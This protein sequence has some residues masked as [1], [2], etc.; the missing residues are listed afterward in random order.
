MERSS[1]GRRY[2]GSSVG[3]Y[4]KAG[5]DILD[6]PGLLRLSQADRYRYLCLCALAKRS[7]PHVGG[8][9]EIGTILVAPGQPM[10]VA[11]L[12]LQ[13]RESAK[14]VANFLDRL[15]KAMPGK[16]SR[17]DGELFLTSYARRQRNKP[18][19]NPEAV[20]ERVR[21]HRSGAQG[22]AN[23]TPLVT[24]EKRPSNAD[25]T[26]RC[27]AMGKGRG[28]NT[29]P[30]LPNGSSIPPDPPQPPAAL[31]G[32]A[33]AVGGEEAETGIDE[34]GFERPRPDSPAAIARAKRHEQEQAEAAEAPR[35][36]A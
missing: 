26:S 8:D 36:Q 2:A 27:N 11:D 12:A 3:P 30:L 6:D 5:T 35:A 20:K 25:V 24:P 18:S 1:K 16:L 4:F 34:Y 15:E 29:T 28:E 32:A 23:V 9:D 19:D 33:P 13:F 17:R 14:A 31:L 21:R 22:N 10:T 7:E